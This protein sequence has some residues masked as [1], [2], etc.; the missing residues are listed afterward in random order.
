MKQFQPFF[1]KPYI[2]IIVILFG[3]IFNFTKLDKTYF[4]EDEVSTIIQTSGNTLSGFYHFFPQNEIK[5]VSYY[6]EK[7]ALNNGDYT[8]KSQISG[9]TKM[10]QFT[11][12]HY[13]LLVFWHRIIGDDYMDY[14]LFSFLVYLLTLPMLFYLTNKI[15]KSKLAAWV[16][17]SLF[18][19][20]PFFSY[21]SIEARY[22]MLWAFIIVA[23]HA[24]FLKCLEDNS[25]RWWIIYGITATIAMYISLFS[26]LAIVSHVIYVY[27][28]N[29]DK[30]LPFTITQAAVFVI[31]LPWIL[32]LYKNFTMLNNAMAWQKTSTWNTEFSI[33]QLIFGQLTSMGKLF[34]WTTSDSWVG[35]LIGDNYSSAIYLDMTLISILT[36]AII[37]AFIYSIK[38]TTTKYKWLILFLIVP[39]FLF[40]LLTDLIRGSFITFLL[41]YTIVSY[42]TVFLAV[43]F[44][45][46]KLFE[47]K[48]IF[49]FTAYFL[50]VLGCLS[51][52]SLLY[53]KPCLAKR[54]DCISN[55]ALAER[56][57]SSGKTLLITDFTPNL[58]NFISV[59][60]ATDNDS[61]DILC[62]YNNY[63]DF[64]N[65]L[66]L[67]NYR[68]LYVVHASQAL[69]DSVKNNLA[70]TKSINLEIIGTDWN[71]T[72]EKK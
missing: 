37:A 50:L 63:P 1:L 57:S 30:W 67:S 59:L 12:F 38:M 8:I 53:N 48:K 20:S 58:M 27:L 64:R 56:F 62:S 9:L 18:S 61:L 5:N 44:A 7:L 55:R 68:N 52:L 11:P 40:I 32:F 66:P 65:E 3:V 14:R 31:Y 28:L 6:H 54:S 17:I 69:S 23:V 21:F 29:K 45:V 60:I 46:A 15:F 16:C 47:K 41:R 51:S 35:A 13:V 39:N 71:W 72:P 10:P 49:F 26:S 4:W 19:I 70:D 25:S 34:L 33:W 42:I 22:Y 43:G 2:Y 36:L 24:A